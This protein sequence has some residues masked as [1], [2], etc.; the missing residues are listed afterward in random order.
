MQV[1]HL[2]AIEEYEAFKLSIKNNLFKEKKHTSIDNIAG[3]IQKPKTSLNKRFR[4]TG[5]EHLVIEG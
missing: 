4:M 2:L 3:H 5:F 1:K